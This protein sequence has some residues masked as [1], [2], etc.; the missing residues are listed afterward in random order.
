MT[1]AERI[2]ALRKDLG[3][4]VEAFGERHGVLRR[5]VESYEQGIRQPRGLALKAI[6]RECAKRG[7]V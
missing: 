1:L 7:I 5:T 6:L 3:L 4:S 2:K